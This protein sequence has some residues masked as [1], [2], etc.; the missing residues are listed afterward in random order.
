VALPEE[1][2]QLHQL[3]VARHR[4]LLE[5]RAGAERQETDHGADLEPER[6]TARQPEDVVVE[7]VLLV[8]HLVLVLA[9]LVHGVGD[10]DEV[11][12]ELEGD[13]LVGRVVVARMTAMS[14]MFWQ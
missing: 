11:L 1:S 6:L 13:L 14:S 5:H 10:P 12:E 3:R 4:L 2:D 9:D 7:A 8:P